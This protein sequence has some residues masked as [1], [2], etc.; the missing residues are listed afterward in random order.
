MTI[1]SRIQYR[2]KRSK[3]SVFMRSDFKD[4]ADYDQVGRCLRQLVSEGLL[5]KISYGLYVRA[6]INRI[7]GKPMPDNPA[8][9]DG[10]MMEALERLNV[11]YSVDEV[12]Q[13][14]LSGNSTQIPAKIKVT[15]SSPRFTRKIKVGSQS[16]N[17]LR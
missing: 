13:S 14:S 10:V 16:V 7:T 2:V 8:G 6:R 17:E 4:I 3:R 1:Q 11:A 12:S 9:S 5:I 15:P